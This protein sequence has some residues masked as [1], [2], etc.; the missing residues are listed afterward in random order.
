MKQLADPKSQAESFQH[1]R[2]AHQSETAEDYV[3]L[4]ADL[5][6]AKGEARVTDLSERF[7]VSHTT[8]NKI[9]TR[10]KK[11]GLVTSQPYRALFLTEEGTRMAKACKARHIIVYDFL[12][13]LGISSKT[14]EIDAEGIEHHVS[15][16]TLEA[17][18][19]YIKQST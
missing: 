15:K 14:A 4:I 3:E 16:E 7:S 17:F 11:E 1:V 5:I 9:I 18:Q 6:A 13:A 10:L 8:V 2:R 19:N 12:K